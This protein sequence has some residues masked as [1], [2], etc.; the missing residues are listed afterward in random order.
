MFNL[1]QHIPLF[2]VPWVECFVVFMVIFAWQVLYHYQLLV[3]GHHCHAVLQLLHQR[4]GP[5][6]YVAFAGHNM[7]LLLGQYLSLV[8]ALAPKLFLLQVFD[9]IFY[10]TLE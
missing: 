8:G 9:S 4:Q 7:H 3:E 5:L 1:V 6:W 2:A 10:F